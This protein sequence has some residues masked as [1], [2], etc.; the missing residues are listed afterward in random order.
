MSEPSGSRA[1]FL[2][3]AEAA[4]SVMSHPAVA[5][6]WNDP[7]ALARM[8][9]GAVAGHLGRAVFTVFE[10]LDAP[11][12]SSSARTLLPSDY[13]GVVLSDTDLDSPLHTGVRARSEAAAADGCKALVKRFG[14]T[15]R[16]LELR[17][18]DEPV[19]RRLAVAGG[20]VMLLDDYLVTRIVELAV[21]SDDLAVSVGLDVGPTPGADVAIS[22][23]VDA[24]RLRH[25]ATAVLRA[26]SR[27]ERDEVSALRVI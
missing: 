11:T 21:H 6:H 25:G 23:L 18:R 8:S 2:A 17:L 4:H 15:V 14:D 12:P 10:Y 1:V 16:R 20:N 26:L 27:R 22:A 5:E 13:L 7:S 3:A 19:D 24:A 9:V